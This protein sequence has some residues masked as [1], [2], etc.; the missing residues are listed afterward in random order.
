LHSNEGAVS[1]YLVVV[2]M[3]PLLAQVRESIPFLY[4]YSQLDVMSTKQS[5]E[6]MIVLI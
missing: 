1:E 3:E 5:P 4:G 6:E 2:E